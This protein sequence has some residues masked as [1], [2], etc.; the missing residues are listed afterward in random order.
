MLP[1]RL[2]IKNFLA[3]QMPD[4]LTLE[5]LHL[6]CLT[7]ENG[8]GKSSL[9]DAM[10]WALWGR[11]RTRSDDDLIHL[12]QEEMAVTL[13]FVQDGQ[14]FR[15]TRRRKL[16]RMRQ[17]G[18]RS[19]GQSELFLFGYDDSRKAFAA[20]N[21]PSMRETQ[22]RINQLLRLDHDIFINSAFL[23]QGQADAFTTKTPSQR[24]EILSEILGLNRWVKYE[25]KAKEEL[26]DI[27]NEITLLAMRIN[28]FEEEIAKQPIL[29]R[30]LEQARYQQ[31]EAQAEVEQAEASL[32][33]V[34]GA[35]LEYRH[36]EE[37]LATARYN[38]RER[39]KDRLTLLE[40]INRHEQRLAQ[41]QQVV[42]HTESIRQG[43]AQLEEARSADL[44]LGDKLRELNTLTQRIAS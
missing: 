37:L 14:R 27:Q 12:G 22:I 28:E 6:A 2:E 38:I 15:V 39:E 13:D 11:A 10:T 9:L 42:A 31:N 3:Y 23:Q 43:Y 20:I 29:E 41:Y 1:V 16:G 44:A 8:A 32:T 18:R 33:E 7:G 5:D 35:D 30:D 24:K 19:P 26:R 40:E 4:P 17:D 34:Q 36:T 21:E 25:E